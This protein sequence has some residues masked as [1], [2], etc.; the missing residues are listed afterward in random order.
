MGDWDWERV[1][2]REWT[3]GQII[4]TFTS[5]FFLFCFHYFPQN[6]FLKNGGLGLGAN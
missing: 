2:S 1:D 4:A 5:M 3:M 6:I